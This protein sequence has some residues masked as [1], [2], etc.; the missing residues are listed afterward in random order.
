MIRLKGEPAEPYLMYNSRKEIIYEYYVK[1]INDCKDQIREAN[2]QIKKQ[3]Q[4][5]TDEKS[6]EIKV[7]KNTR[8]RM[9]N[10]LNK[11]YDFV[12]K[13]VSLLDSE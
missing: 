3:R 4:L 5:G 1:L 11:Y 13:Q 10:R 8:T 7:L 12:W 9:R 6:P 2:Q